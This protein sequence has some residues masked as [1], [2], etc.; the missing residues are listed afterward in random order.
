M[1][2]LSTVSGNAPRTCFRCGQK[3]RT[4]AMVRLC[5]ACRRPRKPACDR[6]DRS[7]SFREKQIASLICQARLNKEIAHELCLSE[8]TVKEY[9]NRIFRKLGMKN[10]TEL[11]MWAMAN[12]HAVEVSDA[13]QQG[14]VT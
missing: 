2:S 6:L 8:G 5:P 1:S 7:L 10:R 4:E 9:L 3:F 12:R 14:S 13:R 11:A